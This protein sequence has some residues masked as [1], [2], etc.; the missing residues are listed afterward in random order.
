ME[1]LFQTPII[2]FYSDSGEEFLHF[3]S[4]FEEHGISHFLTPPYTPVHN[5]TAERRHRHV[6]ETG[7]TLLY[8]VN[9]PLKFRS[10]AFKTAAYFINRLPTPT[11]DGNSPYSR[12]YG[13]LENYN[14]LR[15]FGCLC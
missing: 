4:F 5:A 3:C 1:K 10:Y 6:V 14:K 11:L 9:L 8:N 13:T 7:I 15:V 12:L 2:C